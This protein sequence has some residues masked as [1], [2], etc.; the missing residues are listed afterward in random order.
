MG[1]SG[2]CAGPVGMA[3]SR[4]ARGPGP[5]GGPPCPRR[6]LRVRATVPVPGCWFRSWCRCRCRECLG[7]IVHGE[8][9]D[10][11]RLLRMR[12]GRGAQRSGEC[13]ALAV[14]QGDGG[15]LPHPGDGRDDHGIA[16][17]AGQRL[18]ER[19]PEV[20][21]GGG[22]GQYMGALR[23]QPL[24]Q[25]GVVRE[26]RQRLGVAEDGDARAGRQ[27]LGGQQQTGVDQLGDRVDADH[28]GLAH[29]GGDGAVGDADR[30]H[31]VAGRGGAVVPGPLG[32]HDRFD[33]GGAAGE[34]GEFA[35]VAD[36]LQ[37]QDHDVGVRV[38]VPVLEQV[39]AG[40]VGAVAGRDEGGDTGDTAVT[41]AA[42]MQSAEQGDADGTGLGEQA[43]VAGAGHLRV[44]G[45]RSA[46][47]RG[48]C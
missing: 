24:G 46:G 33:G 44:R 13:D 19:R 5:R 32:D 23:A 8:V 39:V 21:R 47:R 38:V 25:A 20:V 35:R 18:G 3:R 2:G 43:D 40:D 28:A 11:D 10:R 7:E 30:G 16:A 4:Q 42:R 27:R 45:R 36:G 22:R 41:G 37:I 12:R 34:P 9:D 31:G 6:R 17:V 26:Q 48:R 1:G 14:G 29:Q 15:P